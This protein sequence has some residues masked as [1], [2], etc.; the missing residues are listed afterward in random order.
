LPIG[1]YQ[2]VNSALKLLFFIVRVIIANCIICYGAESVG[3]ESIVCLQTDFKDGIPKIG[4]GFFISPTL[5]ATASHQVT[6]PSSV[7]VKITAYLD[8]GAAIKV[9]LP[10]VAQ[11]ERVAI[12][13]APDAIQ[14]NYLLLQDNIPDQGT[15]VSAVGCQRDRK[16]LTQ[17]GKV[18]YSGSNTN[19]RQSE[20]ADLIALNLPINV[21][22]SGG[23]LLTANGHV[24]GIVYGFDEQSEN[25]SYAIPGSKLFKIMANEKIADYG[26]T[27]FQ[28]GDR[29]FKLKQYEMAKKYFAEAAQQQ[30]DYFEAYIYLGM[31]LF[32]MR[33]FAEARDALLEA[34]EIETDYPLAYYHL[35][36]VYREGLSDRLSARNAYRRYLELDPKSSDAVQ[37][38]K[39][40]EEIERP[41]PK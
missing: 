36:G 16:Q 28:Q 37:V 15:K 17:E 32:K 26:K 12:L 4:T 21:G 41:L 1:L 2:K 3:A 23:P 13:A 20:H 19:D 29:A 33:Q 6:D 14:A 7:P 27:L 40:L 10:V 30:A 8:S 39:W 9:R 24:V 38:Q 31:T 5:I 22:F 25:L 34:I 18:T 11:G 35:A